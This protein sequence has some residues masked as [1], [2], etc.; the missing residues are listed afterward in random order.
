VRQTYRIAQIP[1]LVYHQA[2]VFKYLCKIARSWRVIHLAVQNQTRPKRTLRNLYGLSRRLPSRF[3]KDETGSVT[4]E[5][6]LWVPVFVV[7]LAITVDATILF[8]TQANL[9]SI[10]RDTTRQMSTG[11]YPTNSA[12]EDAAYKHMPS[13][14]DNATIEARRDANFVSLS[15]KIPISDVSPFN[16]V[17]TF[18]SGDIAIAIKQ[19]IEPR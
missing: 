5:F 15:I 12:A 11:M 6:V 19:H 3:V 18:T 10:A 17:G 13:W 2:I 9:W 4:I 1:F 7:I 14:R 16:I 8:M